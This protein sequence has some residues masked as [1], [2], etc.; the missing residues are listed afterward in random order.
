MKE[1]NVP[2]TIRLPES[3]VNLIREMAK[4]FGCSPARLASLMLETG[5]VLVDEAEKN[6]QIKPAKSKGKVSNGRV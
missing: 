4:A 3:R 6:N 2:I 1:K 5:F